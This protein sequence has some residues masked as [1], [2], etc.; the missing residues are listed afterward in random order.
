MPDKFQGSAF[1][2]DEQLKLLRHTT[3]PARLLEVPLQPELGE[4]L[5][6]VLANHGF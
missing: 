5:E 3:S 1:V 4:A 6:S 2:T